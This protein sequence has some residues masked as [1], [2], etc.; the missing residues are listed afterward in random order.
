MNINSFKAFIIENKDDSG[1]L[2]TINIDYLMDGDVTVKVYFS[3]FN[4]KDGL[5]IIKKIPIIRRFP[6]IPGV[7]FSG[8]VVDSSCKNYKKGDSVI[9]N[10]WGIGESHFGGFSQYARVPSKWLIKLP[11][12]FNYEESMV[13][14]TA[15]YTA[16]LCVLEVINK[17]KPQKDKKIIVTGASGGVGSICV[18]LLA[19]LGFKVYA[20]SGKDKEF[21]YTLGAYKVISRN[22][23]EISKKP[24]QK[25]IWDA[26]IDTV[27]SDILS[28]ILSQL[29]YDGIVASTGLAKGPELNTT[30]FPFILRNVTLA[31]VD[32]VSAN[33]KKRVKAWNF[34]ANNIDPSILKKIKTKKKISDINEL[35][36]QIVK[37][38]IQGRTI[39]DVN[40]I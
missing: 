30:V 27:G 17:L 32:C 29:K 12:A 18:Y 24:L 2:K 15:G 22:E 26:A 13:I 33:Y 25:E 31:G 34:L 40:A 35:S 3:S 23:F 9:L 20:L 21:L 37:G 16:S 6:M 19:K 28:T 5:A 8:E 1:K 7:D 10:G 4:F 38:M 39:I 36:S 14:G 11:N